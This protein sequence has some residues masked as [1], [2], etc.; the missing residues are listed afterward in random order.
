MTPLLSQGG[1]SQRGSGGWSGA[2]QQNHSLDQHHPV[3]PPRLRR[4]VHEHRRFLMVQRR[5]M[6][7]LIALLVT[8]PLTHAADTV[9]RELTDDAFWKMVS[10]YSEDSGSFRFEYMS[11]E[12]Q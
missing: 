2:G 9:P 6:V 5:V 8:I 4:G 10:D 12:L 7:F 1:E 11:N 3:T